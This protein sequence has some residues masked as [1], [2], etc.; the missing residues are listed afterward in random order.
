[1]RNGHDY[2]TLSFGSRSIDLD[3]ILTD[4]NSFVVTGVRFRIIGAH[5]NLEAKLT[6]MDFET[7]KL[8]AAEAN[9]FWKSNDNTDVS[10]EKRYEN[11]SSYMCENSEY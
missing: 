4:D 3:D 5:L 2:H 9:S 8:I 6:E 1:M 7:G 10:G 11:K